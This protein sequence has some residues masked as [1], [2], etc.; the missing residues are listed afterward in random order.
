VIGAVAATVGDC[1]NT[2]A[3]SIA[4]RGSAIR[5]SAGTS[6][7]VRLI[8]AACNVATCA[9]VDRV[10][11]SDSAGAVSV[12]VGLVPAAA[13]DDTGV[14]D[15]S[16]APS[17]DVIAVVVIAGIVGVVV[18]A[19][20]DGVIVMPT[21]VIAVIVL[22]VPMLLIV[23]ARSTFPCMATLSHATLQPQGDGDDTDCT[24]GRLA[25]WPRSGNGALGG[26]CAVVGSRGVATD[27]LVLAGTGRGKAAISDAVGPAA[28]VG[29][30]DMSRTRLPLAQLPAIAWVY[31]SSCGWARLWPAEL[32]G[33]VA[34][35]IRGTAG[36]RDCNGVISSC[37]D[38]AAAA[39]AA[40]A[41]DDD[42][43]A[44]Y[45]SPDTA[46]LRA[47]PYA[48]PN[49]QKAGGAGGSILEW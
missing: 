10:V 31:L 35:A 28:V 5:T 22:A 18:I 11:G 23:A 30:A 19:V 49:G 34:I 46:V 45:V 40:A 13:A 39:A 36:N 24:C 7:R 12:A 20:D 16:S 15:G 4:V 17:V 48:G 14:A 42:D 44:L 2:S 9:S 29:G 43:S 25:L 47:A 8:P 38:T 6:A 27:V 1:A 32:P 37:G 41:T 21:V 3:G 33:R 26:S